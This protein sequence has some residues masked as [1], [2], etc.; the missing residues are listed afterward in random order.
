LNRI[1]TAQSGVLSNLLDSGRFARIVEEET[2]DGKTAWPAADFLAAVQ[3]GIWSELGKTQVKIDAYR[4]NLQRAYLDL[5]IARVN[6]GNT[7]ERSLYRAQLKSLDSSILRAVSATTDKE[8]RAH[9][10]SARQQIAVA[11]EPRRYDERIK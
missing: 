8:T 11:L 1:R 2:M 7:E 4:R 6:G 5:A 3:A 9:L 10:D